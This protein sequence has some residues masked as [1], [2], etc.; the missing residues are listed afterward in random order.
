MGGLSDLIFGK[1]DQPDPVPP[2]PPPTIADEGEEAAARERKR[3][4]R[5]QGRASTILT[6][7]QPLGRASVARQTLG[8]T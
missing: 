6:V 8:G 2:I 5:A 1:P 3:R 4:R 7:G